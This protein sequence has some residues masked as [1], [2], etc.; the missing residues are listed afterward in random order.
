MPVAHQLTLLLERL[1]H[2]LGCQRKDLHLDHIPALVLRER[3]PSGK[4]K[5]D[6][7]DPNFLLYRTKFDHHERWP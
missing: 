3:L 1:A 6:A 4:F 5:P 7:N 2:A